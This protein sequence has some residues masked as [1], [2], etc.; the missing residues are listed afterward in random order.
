[1]INIFMI[2]LLLSKGT[3]AED[4]GEMFVALLDEEVRRLEKVE[5]RE[6]AKKME[7]S[8]EEVCGSG[9]I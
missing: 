1:M 8:E 7:K 4:P 2:R 3:D 6:K 9:I 5:K